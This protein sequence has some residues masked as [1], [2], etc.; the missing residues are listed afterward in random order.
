[1]YMYIRKKVG[2][3]NLINLR[4]SYFCFNVTYLRILIDSHDSVCKCVREEICFTFKIKYIK[5]CEYLLS[6][7]EVYVDLHSATVKG[8][9][10]KTKKDTNLGC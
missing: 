1:M 10:L 8:T 5:F 3:C 6:N 7:V 9:G 4:D 2:F